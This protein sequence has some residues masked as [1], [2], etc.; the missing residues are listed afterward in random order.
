MENTVEEDARFVCPWCDR[1]FSC[2]KGLGGHKRVHMEATNY[3]IKRDQHPIMELLQPNET[4]GKTS[5]PVC[6]RSFSSEKSLHGHMRK[7]PDRSWRGMKPPPTPP[8]PVEGESSHVA[9]DLLAPDN[10][11]PNPT[12]GGFNRFACNLCGKQFQTYQ[13]LGGHR[14][15]HAKSGLDCTGQPS[16]GGGEE[17]KGKQSLLFTIDLN[18]LPP[19]PWWRIFILIVL[20]NCKNI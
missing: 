19:A 4:A 7:H 12:I 5:C 17:E 15:H 1:S 11:Q 2:G 18:Q 14:S 6:Q 16:V 10:N 20:I 13:A 9:R 8:A 3:M